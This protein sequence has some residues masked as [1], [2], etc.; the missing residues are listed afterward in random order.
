[1]IDPLFFFAL[2]W[3][4]LATGDDKTRIKFNI[5]LRDKMKALNE[6]IVFPEEGDI[7][8]YMFNKE[9][10]QFESWKVLY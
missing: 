8:D 9:L 6:P 1:M 3:S 7:Y 4:V 2:I 5:F 10:K